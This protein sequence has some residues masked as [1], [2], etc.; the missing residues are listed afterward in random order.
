VT[1][2]VIFGIELVTGGLVVIACDVVAVNDVCAQLVK[3]VRATMRML[4]PN[5]MNFFISLFPLFAPRYVRAILIQ[6]FRIIIGKYISFVYY[7]V[8]ALATGPEGGK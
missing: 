2:F 7:D 8:L 3:T 5:Q 4:I 6:Y 1:G